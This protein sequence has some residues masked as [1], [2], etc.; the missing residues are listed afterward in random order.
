MK[1]PGNLNKPLLRI[2]KMAELLSVTPRTLRYYEQLGLISP[3]AISAKGYRYY[4]LDILPVIEKI[5][6]LQTVGLSLDEIK[7]VIGLFSQ[8]SKRAEA[9]RKMLEF[10]QRHLRDIDSRMKLLKKMRADLSRQILVT[11]RRLNQLSGGKRV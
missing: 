5:R 6:D 2:G 11:R 10:M 3:T 7:I 9:K 4:T 1:K 8:E